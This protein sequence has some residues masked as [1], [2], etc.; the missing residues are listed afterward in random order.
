[1]LAATHV[2]CIIVFWLILA[3]SVHYIVLASD[4]NAKFNILDHGRYVLSLN[5]ALEPSVRNL[6]HLRSF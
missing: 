5:P 6:V 3:F 1:M 2:L 4:P